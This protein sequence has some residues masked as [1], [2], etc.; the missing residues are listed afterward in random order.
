MKQ[1]SLARSYAD[2]NEDSHKLIIGNKV[3]ANE[4]HDPVLLETVAIPWVSGKS[5]GPH[6]LFS[7]VVRIL[8][9]KCTA[10]SIKLADWGE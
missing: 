4:I 8:R 3:P 6:E 2:S 5:L 10:C 1:A 7:E 9:D